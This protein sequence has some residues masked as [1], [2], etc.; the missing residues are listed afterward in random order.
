L[1]PQ[2]KYGFFSKE[3]ENK[4]EIKPIQFGCSNT[5]IHTCTS[6]I[7]SGFFESEKQQKIDICLIEIVSFTFATRLEKGWKRE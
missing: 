2:L 3:K 1:Q 4:I 6:L 7:L 5:S